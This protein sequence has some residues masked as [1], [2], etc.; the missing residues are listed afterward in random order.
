MS[1]LQ[2]MYRQNQLWHEERRRH[3]AANIRREKMEAKQQV[4]ALPLSW[5][6]KRVL[7]ALQGLHFYWR[8]VGHGLIEKP[9]AEL[10]AKCR[11]SVN[12]VR[13]CLNEL[14]A[15]GYICRERVGR[16]RGVVSAIRVLRFAIKTTAEAMREALSSRLAWLASRVVA[17]AQKTH[18]PCGRGQSERTKASGR[19]SRASDTA[20][21]PRPIPPHEPLK[22]PTGW[23]TTRFLGAS[24]RILA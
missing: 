16:G 17:A 5:S 3:A 10:A 23:A 19:V 2:R 4:R 24:R 14:E 1:A 11:L 21:F 7:L 20:V 15:G 22:A 8:K 18:Q 12:T 9:I 13:R 6:R